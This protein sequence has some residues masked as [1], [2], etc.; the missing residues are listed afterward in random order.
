MKILSASNS[1][2]LPIIPRLKISIV[3]YLLLNLTLKVS[4]VMGETVLQ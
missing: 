4:K 1:L 3:F 2:N